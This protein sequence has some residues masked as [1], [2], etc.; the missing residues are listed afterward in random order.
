MQY[1]SKEIRNLKF[2]LEIYSNSSLFFHEVNSK[3]NLES[4]LIVVEVDLSLRMIRASNKKRPSILFY[5]DYFQN[6]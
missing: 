4:V 5:S 2:D 1:I 6:M 3:F